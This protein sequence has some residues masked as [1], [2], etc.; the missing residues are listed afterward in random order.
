MAT[1]QYDL[2]LIPRSVLVG[3]FG[4]VPNQ[5]DSDT[6]NDTDW[7]SE[8]ACPDY[9]AA[10]GSLLKESESWSAGMRNWGDDDGNFISVF[11]EDSQIA[12]IGVRFDVRAL[13][14]DFVEGVCNFSKQCDCLFFTEDLKL[15]EPDPSL[16]LDEIG[17]SDAF[18]FV[19]D[20]VGF[21]NRR[22][23]P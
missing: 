7:W 13:D 1:W 21:L 16:L 23:S 2:Q 22:K 8:H 4:S 12:E 15:I 18:A 14:P 11:L 19:S 5:L 3:V 10:L 6:F 17:H 9:E 20:P